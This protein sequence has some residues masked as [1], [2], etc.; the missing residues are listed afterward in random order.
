VLATA[1]ATLPVGWAIVI[2]VVP[3]AISALALIGGWR[4]QS[5]ARTQ[6]ATEHAA[7][8]KQQKDQL[9][10]TLK[11]QKDQLDATLKQQQGQF[12]AT[13][14]LQR[15]QQAESLNHDREQQERLLEHERL[16]DDMHEARTVLDDATRALHEAD[17]RRRAIIGDIDDDDKREALRLAGLAL[18]QSKQQIAFRFGRRHPLTT[19]FERCADT[20]AQLFGATQFSELFELS[21]RNRRLTAAGEQFEALWPAFIDAATAYAGVELWPRQP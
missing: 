8:L 14:T 3:S 4:Q 16:R 12:V 6:Q 7:N 5:A 20:M 13:T 21:D 1:A 19:A 11:Q 10:E 15:N 17:H 2:A 9:D 18:D